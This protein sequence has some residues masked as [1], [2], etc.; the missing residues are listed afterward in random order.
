MRSHPK[1]P[2]HQ[3]VFRKGNCAQFRACSRIW[4][5]SLGNDNHWDPYSWSFNFFEDQNLHLGIL[6]SMMMQEFLFGF[7]FLETPRRS[8]R[9]TS[10]FT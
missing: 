3:W 1:G 2:G 9:F 10:R 8:E 4:A 7:G 5:S 6:I